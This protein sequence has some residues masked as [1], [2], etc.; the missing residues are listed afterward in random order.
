MKKLLALLLAFV[1][2]HATAQEYFTISNYDV[3]INVNKDASLDV[4][5]TINVHFTEPRHGIIRLIPYKYQL[6]SLPEGTEKANRQ[7]NSGGYAHT[8][9]ENIS[10]DGWNYAVSTDGDYKAIKIGSANSTVEGNQQYVIRYR[11]LNAINFFKDH[12]ELYLNVIGDK[13]QTTI[14]AVHFSVT[15]YNALP[16]TP[17]YFVATGALSST[18]NNTVT[19]WD[20]N[21]IFNGST[22]ARLN[23]NEGVTI[24]IVFP[25][26]YLV[27]VNY[28]L[29][30]IGWLALPVVVF[31]MVFLT[32]RRWGKD[33]K[34]TVQTEYY[35]PENISPSISGYII[36]DKLDRRDLTALIPY[37]GAGGYLEVHEK[38]TSALFGLLK[39]K[40]YSFVKR[41]PLPESAMTFEKT[42][43]NGIFASGDVVELDSL[44]DKLYTTMAKAKKQLEQEIKAGEYYYKRSTAIGCW[45][46][47][48]SIALLAGGVYALINANGTWWCGIALLASGIIVIIFAALMRKKTKKGTALYQKLAGFREFI[49]SVE[50]DRLSEFL[51]QDESYFDKILPYAIVFDMADRWK[52]KLKDLDIP[53]PTWY[54]GNYP[55]FTTYAFLSSL[56]HSMNQMS[57]TFYSA[58]SSSGSSGGSF[59]GGGSSGGG[60]GGG[61]GSSW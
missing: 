5:E 40:D 33:E 37:W 13:W 15:L 47:T 60:F 59:G 61:G 9:I 49:S 31:M 17:E 35:P 19:K 30:G 50:K 21:R 56:D 44:S 20:D 51:K 32:W 14:D 12:S 11:L 42:L 54:V 58:P 55:T 28:N 46:T 18:Q 36:D 48:F 1:I 16:A 22:L 24:G 23:N 45:L 41:R 38:Q 53:P 43:F 7:L 27:Q 39:S 2:N 3:A 10:V 26:D 6:Q 57:Q 52:D 34:P 29:K 4:V 8:I 25:Q